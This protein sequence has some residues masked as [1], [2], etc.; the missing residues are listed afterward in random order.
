MSTDTASGE[1]PYRASEA[2]VSDLP[3]DAEIAAAVAVHDRFPLLARA[4]GPYFGHYARRWHLLEGENRM[5]RPWHWPALL[6]DFYWLMYRK[7]YLFAFVYLVLNFIA[8][9]VIALLPAF[10]VA[11][12]LA[13]L[14]LKLALCLSANA[15]YRWRCQRLIARMQAR[16]AGNPE[17]LE[18]EIGRRGGTSGWALALAIAFMAVVS[19][20]TEA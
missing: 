2:E 1:N 14:G 7:L 6:F 15:L 18:T 9:A 3:S 13:L 10:E 12:V 4:V 16:F 11:A 19:V 8:G 17:R 20:L 5:A